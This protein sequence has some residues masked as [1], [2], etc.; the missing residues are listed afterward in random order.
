MDRDILLAKLKKY[1]VK[2]IELKWFES[3]LSSRKQR[4]KIDETL[5]E[6]INVGLAVSQ[7]SVLGALLFIIYVNE[8][9]KVVKYAV[10]RLFADDGLLYISGVNIKECINIDLNKLS[11]WFK[12]NKLSLNI[13][14]TKCMFIN[15]D[16]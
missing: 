2:G 15:G 8:M 7:G 13:G 14:K 12:S 6:A 9:P 1:G 5:S 10:L 4:T 11:E 16:S 3:Y